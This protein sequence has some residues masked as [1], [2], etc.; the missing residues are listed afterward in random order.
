MD[1]KKVLSASLMI[2]GIGV[3]LV[4][5]QAILSVAAII[6]PDIGGIPIKLVFSLV[7][8]AFWA[9]SF[10][11][12][13]GL[14]VWAGM[15]AVKSYGLDPLGG[16]IV[17]ALSHLVVGV[18]S[19][20]VDLVVGV[21]SAGSTV[22]TMAGSGGAT[23]AAAGALVGGLGLM[24]SSAMTIM[25]GAICLFGGLVLNL[26]LGFLGGTLAQKKPEAA[27]QKAAETAP[28]EKPAEKKTVKK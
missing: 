21:I 4:L 26:G 27:A 28:A 16:G 9:V 18:I 23:G 24:L 8:I 25:G 6:V 17:S 20:I 2:M 14:Y 5:V 1:F 19:I 7:G 22:A 3:A 13:A 10:L 15:R 11:L 12:F